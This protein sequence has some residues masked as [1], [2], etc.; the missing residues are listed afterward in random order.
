MSEDQRSMES[1]TRRREDIA[2][3]AKEETPEMRARYGDLPMLQSRERSR[4]Q[5]FKFDDISKDTAGQDISF[6]ARLHII[7][8]MS[9][10]LVFFVFRQ[11]ITTF[12]GVLH[13]KPGVKSLAMVHWA[14]HLRLGSIVRVRG[15]V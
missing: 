8:R 6:T 4:E 7:R 11:Q 5:R 15:R 13:E 12:Q 2:I 3:A 14:E 1:E 10:K 9:A